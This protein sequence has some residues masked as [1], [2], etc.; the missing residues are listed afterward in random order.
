M[1]RTAVQCGRRLAADLASLLLPVV[2][3]VCEQLTGAGGEHDLVCA[4]CW[5]G[6]H[7][8]PHPRCERCGHPATVDDPCAWCEALPPY[9][10]AVRSVCW[11]PG[12]SG[13]Q[14]VHAF[15]YGGWTRVADPMAREM[16]RTSWP[17][18]VLEERAALIPVP[19][20]PTRLRERGYNQSELLAR[21]LGERWR[22]PVW[23]DVL[24]RARSTR[25]QTKLSAGE[26]I[27]NVHG[28]FD[29]S[30]RAARVL[31]GA[32]VVIVDDVVTTAATLNAC[33]AVLFGHGARIISYVTYGRARSVRDAA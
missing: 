17:V 15:K 24:V 14:L 19:L 10:R 8:L 25:T 4:R 7:H 6:V 29:A 5:A 30:P 23:G 28:A 33:A 9:V 31:R 13:G 26:R 32:H 12:G 22:L 3:V 16:S 2:C 21:A 11:V 18:D 27:T 20:A 1:I